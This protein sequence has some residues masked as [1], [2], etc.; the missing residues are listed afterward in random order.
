MRA[1]IL[2]AGMGTRLRPLTLETPKALTIVNGKPLLER[3]IEYLNDKGITDITIV[4]GYLAE[5]FD[6]LKNKYG[7]NLIFNEKYDKYNNIYTMNLV[8]ELLGDSYVIDADIYLN[9]NFF[10]NKVQKST[11]FSP[12]RNS[13]ENEWKLIYD[14]NNEVHGIE[15]VEKGEGHIL[16]GVSYWSERDSDIIKKELT[17]IMNSD[18]FMD[19]YWD[20]IVRMNIDKLNVSI[21]KLGEEDIF[22]IDSLEELEQVKKIVE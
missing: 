19:Y 21:I 16:A 20:D 1:I 10:E 2:A 18:N 6:Y 15:I 22:E 5:K 4:T 8:K 11:Y 13:F 7:V 14:D 3:Q 9:R 17:S 12:Y